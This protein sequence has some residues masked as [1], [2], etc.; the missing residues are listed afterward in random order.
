MDRVIFDAD[1]NPLVLAHNARILGV[2]LKNIKFA[3]LSHWHYDHYGGM[4]YIAELNPGIKL[5]APIEG[6]AMAMRWGFEPVPVR[7]GGKIEDKFYTSGVLEGIEHAM[8]VETSSGLVIIVGC[9]HPGVDRLVEEVLKV[10][11]NEKAYLVIGGFH[12]PP[13]WRLN[14]LAELSELIAPAHC[15]GDVAK[16]YIKKKFPDKFVEVRTGT[17]IDV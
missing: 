6:M 4:P 5:Y 16:D 7:D 17:I 15:S 11:G 3:F 10:S 1:T 13:I 2:S 12:S 8:G 14:R 9:S